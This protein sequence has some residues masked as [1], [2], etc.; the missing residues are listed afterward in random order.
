MTFWSYYMSYS[1]VTFLENKSPNIFPTSITFLP[2]PCCTI[3]RFKRNFKRVFKRS[4]AVTSSPAPSRLKRV[5]RRRRRQR[6]RRRWRRVK[7]LAEKNEVGDSI[8][9]SQNCWRIEAAFFKSRGQCDW[10]LWPDW[11]IFGNSW[12]QILLQK[13][14]KYF[15]NYS[16][17]WKTWLKVKTILATF[18]AIFGEIGLLFILSSGHTCCGSVY[19]PSTVLNRLVF[20]KRGR[21]FTNSLEIS[22]LCLKWKFFKI[23]RRQ[24]L[25]SFCLFSS[26]SNNYQ[27]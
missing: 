24:T 6:R 27:S 10:L 25:A 22:F 7:K 23:K 15:E 26:H 16:G 3:R 19:L 2:S 4:N 1:D 8:F 9:Y 17:F 18:L 14:P 20:K 5:A 11:A 13:W 21:E 12:K